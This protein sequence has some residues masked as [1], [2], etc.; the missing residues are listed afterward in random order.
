MCSGFTT[1]RDGHGTIH[2]PTSKPIRVD[3][4]EVNTPCRVALAPAGSEDPRIDTSRQTWLPY[5][6]TQVQP[7]TWDDTAQKG[8][9][10]VVSPALLLETPATYG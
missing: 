3:P 6:E 2:L 9:G 4:T 1:F 5:P 7:L 10:T 8:N